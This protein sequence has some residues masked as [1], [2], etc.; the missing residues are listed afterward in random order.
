MQTL[1]AQIPR[2]YNTLILDTC[3]SAEERAFYLDA[4]ARFNLSY[5]ALERQ[6]RGGEHQ[7]YLSNQTNFPRRCRLYRGRTNILAF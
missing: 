3:N 2:S 1:S 5:R 7:R 4:T 6:I